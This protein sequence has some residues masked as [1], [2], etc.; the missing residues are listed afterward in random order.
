MLHT[1]SSCIRALFVSVI[2][3]LVLFTFV[4]SLSNPYLGVSL[5]SLRHPVEK[6]L[7]DEMRSDSVK[8]ALSEAVSAGDV[9]KVVV[10]AMEKAGSYTTNEIQQAKKLLANPEFAND[11]KK[12]AQRGGIAFSQKLRAMIETAK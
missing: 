3:Y 8:E 12:A 7:V 4:P 9:E 11:I 1:I 5:S 10:D 2:I 6:A